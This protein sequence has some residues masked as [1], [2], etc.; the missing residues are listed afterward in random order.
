MG[1]D[2]K[3]FIKRGMAAQK[4]V[5][6]ILAE[7]R[8]IKVGDTVS[9]GT[10][11]Q[12]DYDIGTVIEIEHDRVTVRWKVAEVTYSEHIDELTRIEPG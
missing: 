3:D 7:H 6:D 9:I 2:P 11:G 4:A 8:A 1:T 5:D 10:E 12:A